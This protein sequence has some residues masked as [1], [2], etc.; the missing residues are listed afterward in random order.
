MALGL[1]SHRQ[2]FRFPGLS[3]CFCCYLKCFFPC[4]DT[5][6]S[7]PSKMNSGLSTLFFFFPQPFIGRF[8]VGLFVQSILLSFPWLFE[9][10]GQNSVLVSSQFLV[11]APVSLST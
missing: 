7:K 3:E 9:A 5:F 1:I 2:V 4:I 6:C 8:G 11:H 10:G